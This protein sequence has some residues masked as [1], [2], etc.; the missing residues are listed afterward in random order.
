MLFVELKCKP[1]HV[2][3]IRNSVGFILIIISYPE[4]NFTTFLFTTKMCVRGSWFQCIFAFNMDLTNFFR[5]VFHSVYCMRDAFFPDLFI[6]PTLHF[7]FC[8]ILMSLPS[9]SERILRGKPAY[10]LALRLYF[11][12]AFI[13]NFICL[14]FKLCSL[15]LG[16]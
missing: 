11:L 13:Y 10:A 8:W 12:V 7:K 4:L 3:S 1:V 2:R 16:F 15:S 14:G 9:Y 5:S 6:S